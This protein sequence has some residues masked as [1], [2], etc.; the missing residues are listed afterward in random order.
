MGINLIALLC[1]LLAWVTMQGH[2]AA[3]FSVSMVL[4]AVWQASLHCLLF[5]FYAM[6][7]FLCCVPVMDAPAR[8]SDTVHAVQCMCSTWEQRVLKTEL[9]PNNFQ[10]ILLYMMHFS[11]HGYEVQQL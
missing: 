2:V 5:H 4:S 11:M 6:Q 3:L 1:L 10:H 7:H 8:S 9:N